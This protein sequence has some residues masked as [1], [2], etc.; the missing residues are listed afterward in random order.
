MI[1]DESSML[2][3]VEDGQEKAGGWGT[4]CLNLFRVRCIFPANFLCAATH[5][6]QLTQVSLFNLDLINL[7]LL[8]PQTQNFFDLTP[9][10][11]TNIRSDIFHQVHRTLL[12]PLFISQYAF[13]VGSQG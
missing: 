8:D 9:S 2:L 6:Q 4:I 12:P 5:R 13:P 7:D 11:I 3:R 1:V 10:Q